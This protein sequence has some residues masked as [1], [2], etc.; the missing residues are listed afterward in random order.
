MPNPD[1]YP[2][3]IQFREHLHSDTV[4]VVKHEDLHWSDRPSMMSVR[5]FDIF[6]LR[7]VGFNDTGRDM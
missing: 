3:R 1:Q 2:T 4:V 5:V 7:E 6:G